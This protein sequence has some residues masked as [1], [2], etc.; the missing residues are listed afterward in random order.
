MKQTPGY[1][2]GLGCVALL[3]ALFAMQVSRIVETNNEQSY[4]EK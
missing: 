1:P 3:Y 2:L 4:F